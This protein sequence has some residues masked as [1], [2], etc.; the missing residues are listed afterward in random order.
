[1]K[2]KTISQFGR[3]A[4]LVLALTGATTILAAEDASLRKGLLGTWQ[5]AVVEGDGSKPG[6]QRFRISELVITTDKITAKDGQGNSLGSGAYQ[7]ARSGGTLTIDATG[8]GGQMQGKTYLG[9][10]SVDG[11]TLKWCSG[12]P[13]RP[14]PTQFKST[15]PDGFLMVLTRKQP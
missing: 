10:C 14:R 8:T 5:G 13:Q 6:G 7:L 11:N 4:L 2:S 12:N 15:P 1:M 9:I 3:H